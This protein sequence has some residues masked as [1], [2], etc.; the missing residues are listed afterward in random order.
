M[1]TQY[2]QPAPITSTPFP[3]LR[4]IEMK[5]RL[6]RRR[7]SKVLALSFRPRPQ[8]FGKPLPLVTLAE[9]DWLSGAVETV[10]IVIGVVL[11]AVLM[12]LALI[13]GGV[14]AAVQ[15]VLK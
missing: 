11:F 3:A 12:M 2:T 14:V 4:L 7:L 10:V 9:R 1:R 8:T 13:V 15:W 5:L 6:P